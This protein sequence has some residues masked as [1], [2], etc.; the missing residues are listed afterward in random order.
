MQKAE[1]MVSKVKTEL[2]DYVEKN[3]VLQFIEICQ[4]ICEIQY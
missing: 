4:N 2:A 3:F 1:K